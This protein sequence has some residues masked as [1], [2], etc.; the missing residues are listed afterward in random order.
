MRT[1]PKWLAFIQ[2][3]LADS[4]F[5]SAHP[6]IILAQP[7]GFW[8]EKFIK[9]NKNFI[10]VKRKACLAISYRLLV[11]ALVSGWFKTPVERVAKITCMV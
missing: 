9:F 1:H 11:N 2:R 10:Y 6:V 3:R 5:A 8:Q 4:L 7:V